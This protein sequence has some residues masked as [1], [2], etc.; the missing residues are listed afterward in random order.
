MQVDRV[1]FTFPGAALAAHNCPMIWPDE[2]LLVLDA[3][4]FCRD[5]VESA[6]KWFTANEK[7]ANVQSNI[8]RLVRFRPNGLP[9]I[10]GTPLIA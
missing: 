4:T 3:A 7:D 5:I 9:R 10:I 1:I 2:T 6:R 8:D